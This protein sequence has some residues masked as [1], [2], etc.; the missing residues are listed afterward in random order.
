MSSVSARGRGGSRGWRDQAG[1]TAVE[2]ALVI[3]VF[4]TLLIGTFQVAWVMH[5]A[6][7][8]RWSLESSAR[9]L[10]LDPTITQ[11]QVQTAV[12]SRLSGMVDTRKVTITLVTDNSTAG[13]PVFRASSAYQPSLSIPFVANFPLTLRTTTTVPTP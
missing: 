10:L 9:S 8:V 11:D 6:G 12:F 1:A 4:I 13:A 7:T 3:P 5:C 2:F